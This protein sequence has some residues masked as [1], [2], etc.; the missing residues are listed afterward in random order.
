M[1]SGEN[2]ILTESRIWRILIQKMSLLGTDTQRHYFGA[3]G[4]PDGERS[5]PSPSRG[6]YPHLPR[7]SKTSEEENEGRR[8]GISLDR[9]H[10]GN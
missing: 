6:W 1:E 2:L 8:D 5:C 9:Q 10:L 7:A 3:L 4:R